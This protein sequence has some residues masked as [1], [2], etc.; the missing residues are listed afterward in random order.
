MPM[1]EPIA[2]FDKNSREEVRVSVDEY[3]GRKIINLRVYYRGPNEE[4]LPG[5]Q[6]LAVGVDQYRHLAGAVL[7][8]G[9]W[10]EAHGMLP[11]N[12]LEPAG[13]P[14]SPK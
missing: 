12:T 14:R 1:S 7:D 2:K 8:L 6:G 11:N 3:H 10:L 13:A 4:W 5:K 9:R